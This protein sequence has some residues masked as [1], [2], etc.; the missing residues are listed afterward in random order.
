MGGDF[1]D[2]FCLPDGLLA[3]AA[4]HAMDRG[5]E[6]ALAAA[7]MKAA[8]RAHGQYYR[9]AQQTLRRLNLTMWTGSAGDHHGTLFFG[10]IQTSTGQINCAS[11]GQP[12]V[13]LLRPDGWQSLS[14]VAPRLGES[15]EAEYEQHGYQLQPGETLVIFTEGVRDAA[16][17]QGCPL[18]EAGV[19]E[20]LLGRW[21]VRPRSWPPWSA[22]AW[23]R[24]GRPPGGP[25]A[26]YW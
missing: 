1:H 18:G 17:A 7:A 3:V 4:G 11:A 24:L 2:W 6:A 13:L 22:T 12:G 26:A 20:A 15:P 9:E 14:Q 5:I 10:L 21:T 8:L 19:A 16:D 25:I 23:R